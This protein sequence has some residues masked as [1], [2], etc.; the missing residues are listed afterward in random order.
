MRHRKQMVKRWKMW[1]REKWRRGVEE[2]VVVGVGERVAE[3]VVV[4]EVEV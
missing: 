1:R 3:E 2:V 4:E